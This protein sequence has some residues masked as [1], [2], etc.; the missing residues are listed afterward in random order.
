MPPIARLLAVLAAWLVGWAADNGLTLDPEQVT[1]I[2]LTIY[3]GVHTL[4]RKERVKRDDKA[5]ISPEGL[6]KGTL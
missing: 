4:Y 3:A 5:Q 1:A 2:M 6:P